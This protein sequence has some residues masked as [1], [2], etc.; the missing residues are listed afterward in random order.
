MTRLLKTPITGRLTAPVASSCI[1]MLAGLSKC[2]ILRMPP[3]FWA[4]AAPGVTIAISNAVAA[5]APGRLNVI[6]PVS[7]QRSY[8]SSQTSSMRQPLK[9]LLTMGVHPLT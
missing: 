4:N 3:G 9:R 8:W 1:D 2:D 7:R 5:A 6:S